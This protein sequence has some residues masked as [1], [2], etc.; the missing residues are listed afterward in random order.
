MNCEFCVAGQLTWPSKV[1]SPGF[2]VKAVS[3]ETAGDRS[4]YRIE[5]HY[6]EVK[7]EDEGWLRVDPQSGWLLQDY[8]MKRRRLVRRDFSAQAPVQ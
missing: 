7:S 6:G 3:Q 5:F 1:R 4:F 8:F 2:Q